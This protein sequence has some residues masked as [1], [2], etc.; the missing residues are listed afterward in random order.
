MSSVLDGSVQRKTQVVEQATRESD[1]ELSRNIEVCHMING[2]HL[3]TCNEKRRRHGTNIL[4][5]G[6]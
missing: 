4:C 5:L 1:L 3:V 6:E 2:G